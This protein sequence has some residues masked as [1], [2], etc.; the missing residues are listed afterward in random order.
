MIMM[1][2]LKPSVKSF[3]SLLLDDGR[4]KEDITV[5]VHWCG[6]MKLLKPSVKSFYSLLLDDGRL[7]EDTTVFV[8]WC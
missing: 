1:K 4:L 7:K 8:H 2:L 6:M 3:Y 5:F